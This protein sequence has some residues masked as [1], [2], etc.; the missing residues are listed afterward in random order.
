[1]SNPLVL[2]PGGIAA[3][4]QKLLPDETAEDDSVRI[5]AVFDRAELLAATPY[6]GDVEVTVIGGFISG[7]YFYGTGTVT[8]K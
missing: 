5:R 7:L 1:M 8:I 4:E 6:N 2:Y 3:D